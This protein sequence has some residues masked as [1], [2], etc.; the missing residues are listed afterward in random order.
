MRWDAAEANATLA[1][2]LIARPPLAYLVSRATISAISR[3]HPSSVVR[4]GGAA[5]GHRLASAVRAGRG[6]ARRGGSVCGA[7]ERR[8]LATVHEGR[9]PAE[10]QQ[11]E[12][13]AAVRSASAV[14][15]G[16]VFTTQSC[17][18]SRRSALHTTAPPHT[19]AVRAAE[20]RRSSNA[21]GGS[22]APAS[23]P[24][25]PPLRA[26]MVVI[27]RPSWMALRGSGTGGCDASAFAQAT[28]FPRSS[29]LQAQRT[30]SPKPSPQGPQV[31]S[32]A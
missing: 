18:H 5:V 19:E 15:I 12:R 29:A 30:M 23:V 16:C 27:C 4:A 10:L 6:R 25:R 24:L 17:R 8:V 7:A 26:C 2:F 13:R 31:E 14:T 9:C 1:A 32:S 20:H 11:V 22:H 21:S 28:N 3:R